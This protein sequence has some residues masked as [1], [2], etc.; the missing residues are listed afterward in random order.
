[1]KIFY[2]IQNNTLDIMIQVARKSDDAVRKMQQTE[3]MIELDKKIDFPLN[4]R[5]SYP[6]KINLSCVTT[7]PT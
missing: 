6:C 5:L 1:M 2:H 3:Q 7:K 4:V